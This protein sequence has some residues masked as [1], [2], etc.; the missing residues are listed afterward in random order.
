MQSKNN[1]FEVISSDIDALKVLHRKLVSDSRGYLERMFCIDELKDLMQ[2]ESIVQINHTHTNLQGTVR[3]MHYQLQPFA[4]V[5]LV[6]CLKGRV[7]DVALDLR[8]NSPTFLK[9]FAI[10]LN[11]HNHR[12]LLIPKGFAHGFQTLTADCEM[13]YFHTSRYSPDHERGLNALDPLFNI[14]WP[15]PISERSPRDQSHPMLTKHFQGIEI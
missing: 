10:E 6:S 2:G 7:L 12:T 14:A 4:E 11:E 5:K 1:K 13:L 15:L 9:S 8:A 3:G